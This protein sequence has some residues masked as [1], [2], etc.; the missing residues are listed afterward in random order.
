MAQKGQPI[1][2]ERGTLTFPWGK[3]RYVIEVTGMAAITQSEIVE[4]I[5]PNMNGYPSCCCNVILY[6]AVLSGNYMNS[7]EQSMCALSGMFGEAELQL[8]SGEIWSGTIVVSNSKF[9]G[10]YNQK[11]GK[12]T[13]GIQYTGKPIVT[14]VKAGE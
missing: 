2:V 13:F 7:D 9:E 10:Q 4:I 3:N 8:G 11:K 12:L 14:R 1:P 5:G 6:S